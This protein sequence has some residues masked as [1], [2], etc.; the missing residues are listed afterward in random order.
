MEFEV[1]SA[2]EV[3]GRTPQVLDANHPLAQVRD[4]ENCLVIQPAVGDA[5]T[6]RGRGAGRRAG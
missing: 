6:V 3:L 5:V 2:R 4:E 1:E